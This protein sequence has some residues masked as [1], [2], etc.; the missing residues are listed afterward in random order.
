MPDEVIPAV[1]S[2]PEKPV[3]IFSTAILLSGTLYLRIIII[4]MIT[5]K[6]DADLL[7]LRV[8]PNQFLNGSL[9]NS[10]MTNMQ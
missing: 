7:S 3:W 2:I 4:K 9:F 1:L 5:S 10:I 8:K 6:I